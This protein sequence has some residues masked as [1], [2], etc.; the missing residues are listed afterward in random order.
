MQVRALS[1]SRDL[2]C[3]FSLTF[4]IVSNKYCGN[5]TLFYTI[6]HYGSY[7]ESTSLTVFQLHLNHGWNS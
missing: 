7:I 3:T 4:S 5:Y 1:F 2:I 6:E